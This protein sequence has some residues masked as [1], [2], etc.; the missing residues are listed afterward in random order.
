MDE[1]VGLT[2]LT[3]YASQSKI[4]GEGRKF[5]DCSKSYF[6][7]QISSQSL[8]EVH[9]YR[10]QPKSATKGVFKNIFCL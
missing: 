6:G 5:L 1:G 7:S 3:G 10:L 9:I 4:Q 8:N 2:N